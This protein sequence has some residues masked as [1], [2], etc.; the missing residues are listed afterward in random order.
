M[1]NRR[2]RHTVNSLVREF[3]EIGYL[4]HFIIPAT[5]ISTVII[6]I[7]WIYFGGPCRVSMFFRIPY[8]GFT[9]ASYYILWFFMFF[10]AGGEY[11]IIIHRSRECTK[12]IALLYHFAA[13]LCM[14]LWYPLFFNSF[15]QFLSLIMIITALILMVLYLKEVRNAMYILSLF[16]FFKIVVLIFFTYMNLVF[17]IIN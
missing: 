12:R 10:I 16:A 9:I 14:I 8:K 7:S 1:L 11:V 6:F 2:K 3:R 17:L 4:K 15:S 5:I 13:H